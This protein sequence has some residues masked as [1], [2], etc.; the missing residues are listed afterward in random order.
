LSVNDV[1]AKVGSDFR[2]FGTG[3]L[4]SGSGPVVLVGDLITTFQNA[5]MRGWSPWKAVATSLLEQF[6]G[7]RGRT[8]ALYLQLIMDDLIQNNMAM[9]RFMDEVDSGGLAKVYATT[10]LR[11]GGVSRFTQQARN[12][13]GKF[14]LSGSGLGKY[15]KHSFDDLLRLSKGKFNDY[16]K[17]LKLLEQYGIT[18]ADWDVIRTTE[19]WNPRGNLKF[20]D[21]SAIAKRTDLKPDEAT[22]IAYKLKDLI[23]TEQDHMIVVNSLKS[24]AITSWLKRGTVMGEFGKSAFMFKS[25]PVNVVMFNLMRAMTGPPGLYNKAKYTSM[26]IGGMTM[27]GATIILIDDILNGRDPRRM[28]TREFWVQSLL[29]GGALGPFG[30]LLVGDPDARQ[31]GFLATGPI[32][33]FFADVWVFL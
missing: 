10:L 22:A 5:A 4:L 28:N 32:A 17:T 18:K 6:K 30:D 15:V 16:G 25:F 29:R 14:M 2:H 20:I 9:G 12:A 31:F 26:L 8:E 27:T 33:S 11:V 13:T 23:M 3:T 19:M 7:K 21:P 1:V 24:Q